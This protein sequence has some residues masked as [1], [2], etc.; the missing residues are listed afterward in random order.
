[1]PGKGLVFDG[2][3]AEDFK[4]ATGTWVATGRLRARMIDAFAPYLRDAVLTGPD[5]DDL[6]ALLLP[7][8]VACR[9]LA[10]DVT[11]DT[12]EL[13]ADPAWARRISEAARCSWQGGNRLVQPHCTRHADDGPPLARRR[14]GDR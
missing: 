5:R 13:L 11:G 14:R 10:P 1:D 2:R 9:A 7:D 3:I 8:P 4:L 12:A 6:G